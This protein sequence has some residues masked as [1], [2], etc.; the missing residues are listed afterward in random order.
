M[1]RSSQTLSGQPIS[2]PGAVNYIRH[3]SWTSFSVVLLFFLFS[4][5]FF[6]FPG[7]LILFLYPLLL[8]SYSKIECPKLCRFG[9]SVQLLNPT[10]S[11]TVIFS[12]NLG[13][14]QNT[15]TP[16]GCPFV[17][18]VIHLGMCIYMRRSS[19]DLRSLCLC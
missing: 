17:L 1:P 2:A 5:F 10:T 15:R 12:I 7:F 6:L 9:L 3:A 4:F 8:S 18:V 14:L 13:W 11:Y 19:A 16:G